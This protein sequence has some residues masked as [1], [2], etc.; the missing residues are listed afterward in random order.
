MRAIAVGLV[1]ASFVTAVAA[2]EIQR[3]PDGTAVAFSYWVKF[4][5]SLETRSACFVGKEARTVDGQPLVIAVVVQPPKQAEFLRLTFPI[6]VVR[7]TGSRIVFDGKSIS[8]Q[9]ADFVSCKQKVGCM[10]DYTDPDTIKK[11]RTAHTM[12]LQATDADG[13]VLRY[14]FSLADFANAYDGPENDPSL[15]DRRSVTQQPL[16]KI[17]Q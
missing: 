2:E 10:A 7:E 4:C 17:K 13:G 1:M 12:T 16:G 14:I 8:A 9:T 6:T 15:I 3:L 11:M 5:K